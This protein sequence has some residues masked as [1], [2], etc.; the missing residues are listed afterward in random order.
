MISSSCSLNYPDNS[1]EC[2]ARGGSPTLL[3]PSLTKREQSLVHRLKI[4]INII[5]LTL[6]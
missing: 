4:H 2:G 1:R 5:V 6:I 3:Y